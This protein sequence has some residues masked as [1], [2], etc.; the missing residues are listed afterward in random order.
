MRFGQKIY[1]YLYT[2][3]WAFILLEIL[4]IPTFG[5]AMAIWDG[6]KEF[7]DTMMGLFHEF[8]YGLKQIKKEKIKKANGSNRK[9]PLE[10][11]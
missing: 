9:P 4:G 2:H 8:T 7:G 5:L 10:I 3:Y 11:Y 1:K 6:M